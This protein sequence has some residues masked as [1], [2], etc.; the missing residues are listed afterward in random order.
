[1]EK[2][3]IFIVDDD[4]WYGEILEY[5]LSMNPDYKISRFATAKECLAN[6]SKKPNLI[7]LDYQLPD[8]TGDE[9]LKK[10][11]K[12]DPNIPVIVI[13]AQEEIKTAVELLKAGAAEYFV[14]DVNTKDLLWNAI[15]RLREHQSLK[16]EVE[17]LR[18]ELGHKY[19]FSNLIKGNSPALQKIF[20]LIEKAAKT[21]INVSITGETGTGKEVVAKAIHHNSDRKKKNLVA[22]NMAAIPKELIESELFGHEKGAFTGAIARKAG[23]FEEANQGT[24][25]LDEIAELDLSLQSK[26]LRVIQERELVRVG[27]N[28]KVHLDVRIIVATHKDL[29][30]EVKNGN[31]REDLYYRII[32]L[33]IDLPPLRERGNDILLLAKHFLTEFCKQNKMPPITIS[34]AA[35]NKL[36]TYNYPGNVRELKAI[37]DLASVMCSN[38]EILPEDIT[39]NSVS[40]NTQFMQQEKTLKSYTIDII[41]TFLKK[42]DNNVLKVAEKLD[43]GKS[44]IYKLIQEKEINI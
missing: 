11:K 30:T 7:T 35:K 8:G 21:N 12:V 17:H 34:Q 36:M 13:S 3:S 27:G 28:E 29:A 38:N 16:Q 42:Y 2:F 10:I 37:I 26:L 14:K 44:T 6:L 39:F 24:L 31:F 43:I 22:V 41:Q 15:I 23:K 1:M 4:P 40:A 9:V 20:T 25:F 18:E 19:D 5:Y 32:G 33:P